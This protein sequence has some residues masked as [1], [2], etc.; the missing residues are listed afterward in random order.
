MPFHYNLPLPELGMSRTEEPCV[1]LKWLVDAG[2][3]LHRSTVIAVVMSSG[4]CYEIMTNGDGF[5][6]ERTRSE[7]ETFRV[8]ETLAVIS[9]D[10]E[11]IPYNRPYSLAR[12]CPAPTAPST[13]DAAESEVEGAERSII[14]KTDEAIRRARVGLKKSLLLL[15]LILVAN[16]PFLR[17]MPLHTYFV[18]LGQVLLVSFV[19]AFAWAAIACSGFMSARSYRREAH[20]LLESARRRE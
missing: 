15:A 13:L 3:E 10:G 4:S 17:G 16:V 1:L 20:E 9:A 7:G 19:L 2:A 12:P 8:G 11:N 18:P 5:L 14:A 6:R